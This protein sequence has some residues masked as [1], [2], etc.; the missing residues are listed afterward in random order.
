MSIINKITKLFKIYYISEKIQHSPSPSWVTILEPIQQNDKGMKMR[1][2]HKEGEMS[3]A[4]VLEIDFKS[5]VSLSI[6]STFFWP[7]PHILKD[8]LYWR[9]WDK[10]DQKFERYVLS[11][12][13]Y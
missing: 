8:V 1:W 3:H 10:L 5:D 7:I 11:C 6:K 12:I 13:Q 4:L 9:L 2:Q